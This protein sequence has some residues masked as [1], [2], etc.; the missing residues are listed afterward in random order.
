[1]KFAARYLQS[2]GTGT[3]N[4]AANS[5]SIFVHNVVISNTS[6]TEE[7]TITFNTTDSAGDVIFIINMPRRKTEVLQTYMLADRGFSFTGTGDAPADVEITVF[8]SNEGA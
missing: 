4:V 2:N 5:R 6:S 8:Y 7:A 1:M 3:T